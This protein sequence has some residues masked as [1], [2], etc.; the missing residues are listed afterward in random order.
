MRDGIR[1][2]RELAA[3]PALKALIGES[4]L[5]LATDREIRDAVSHY[6][7]PVGT[8]AMGPA[9][10]P[11]AVCDER[12]RVHGLEGLVVCDC[13]LMPQVPRANTNIPAVLIG[14]RIA[15]ALL[16]GH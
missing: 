12:G 10:D 8:C 4:L 6:Y 14:E 9:G 2:V 15:R 5:P 11:L 3:Q 1:L 13:S 16:S 7:H